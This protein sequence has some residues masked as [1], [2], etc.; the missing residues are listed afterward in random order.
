MI[1]R[2]PRSTLFPY[3]TLFRSRRR[4]GSARMPRISTRRVLPMALLPFRECLVF[5]LVKQGSKED[6]V[7]VNPPSLAGGKVANLVR[8]PFVG[9]E[10]KHTVLHHDQVAE[11]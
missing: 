2:P 5:P 11:D 9:G 7:L 8:P 10:R 4:S 3:T 6:V 1:R